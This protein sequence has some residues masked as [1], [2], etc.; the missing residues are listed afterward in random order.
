MPWCGHCQRIEP[1]YKELSEKYD[2]IIFMEVNMENGKD[3]GDYYGITGYPTFLIYKTPDSAPIKVV[4]AD[5]SRL[6]TT[7][8]AL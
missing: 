3:I 7:L 4:G 2:N 6:E 5:M 1:L 8:K